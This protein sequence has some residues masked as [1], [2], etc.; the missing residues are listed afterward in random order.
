[1]IGKN[2]VISLKHRQDRR[3]QIEKEFSRVG[4]GFYFF[5][6]HEGDNKVLAF[7][8]SQY[9][10][11]LEG[12]K[13]P[14]YYFTIYE[15]DCVFGPYQ[16]ATEAW[17]E[18][19]MD[20]GILQLGCN[21]VGIPGVEFKSPDRHS[22][23]LFRLYDAFQTHSVVYSRRVAQHIIDTWDYK[24][25]MIYDEWLRVNIYKE[26]PCFVIAPQITYQRPSFSDI[27][28]CQTDYSSCFTE[29]NKLLV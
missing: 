24:V 5:D 7:N 8:A 15:D 16:H 17:G 28:Q 27:W 12:L 10:C 25:P 19:P 26:F 29:G 21:L 18:L 14:C 3:V 2:Y 6:A 1:M 13:S 23:H 20:L 22:E 4:L 9:H 11:L